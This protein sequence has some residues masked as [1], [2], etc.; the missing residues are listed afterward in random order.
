MVGGGKGK[1]PQ[2]VPNVGCTNPASALPPA[3]TTSQAPCECSLGT[4]SG[5]NPTST[6]GENDL[7]PNWLSPRATKDAVGTRG[8]WPVIK[9]CRGPR[10]PG[11]ART[12]TVKHLGWEG[13]EGNGATPAFPRPQPAHPLRRVWVGRRSGSHRALPTNTFLTHHPYPAPVPPNPPWRDN[14]GAKDQRLRGER[15]S[16]QRGGDPSGDKGVIPAAGTWCWAERET[17][18]LRPSDLSKRDDSS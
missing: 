6:P 9:G 4:C 8:P 10:H 11:P 13:A 3:K 2:A 7:N 16:E 14:S 17:R 1:R 5:R 18:P 15:L 12:A